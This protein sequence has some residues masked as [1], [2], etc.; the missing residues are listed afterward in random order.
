MSDRL[1][2]I[3]KQVAADVKAIGRDF[4]PVDD[5]EWLIGEV[6]RLR[7]MVGDPTCTVCGGF[8]WVMK[9]KM[10]GGSIAN[11]WNETCRA[12]RGS[13]IK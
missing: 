7:E 5:I 12:C 9:T 13:R 4:W 1:E 2:E 6:E 3:K 11:A 8:G 10:D